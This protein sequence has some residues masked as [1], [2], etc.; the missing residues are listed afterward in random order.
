M[1]V[2]EN[3]RPAIAGHTLAATLAAPIAALWA[4][5]KRRQTRQ[6]LSKLSDHE[7]DDIGLSR[8]TIERLF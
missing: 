1:A 7:L 2:Y 8:D 3:S 5:S 4:W 6:L